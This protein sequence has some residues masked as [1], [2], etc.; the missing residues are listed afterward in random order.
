MCVSGNDAYMRQGRRRALSW[1]F[2]LLLKGKGFYKFVAYLVV[3]WLFFGWYFLSLKCAR[4]KLHKVA[5]QKLREQITAEEAA[6]LVR[7]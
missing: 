6:K 4:Q 2:R 5:K 1:H 3:L 7:G